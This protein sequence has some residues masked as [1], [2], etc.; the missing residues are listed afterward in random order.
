MQQSRLLPGK[1]GKR[2]LNWTS[3]T[4]PHSR[5]SLYSEDPLPAGED[6]PLKGGI[7]AD[8]SCFG[9]LRKG[10]CGRG[11]GHKTIA[12]GIFRDPV[13]DYTSVNTEKF[14]DN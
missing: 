9:G 8:G 5:H 1:Q 2:V 4:R 7:E 3:V 6:I 10:K 12:F 11:A 13:L 14:H